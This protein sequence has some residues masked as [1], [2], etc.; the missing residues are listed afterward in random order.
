MSIKRAIEI[1]HFKL[2]EKEIGIEPF[3]RLI[4]MALY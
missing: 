2:K 3:G 4:Y 1:N